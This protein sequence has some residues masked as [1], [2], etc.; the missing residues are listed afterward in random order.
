MIRRPP[1]ST[2]FPYTT[3]FRSHKL[4][5]GIWVRFQFYGECKE[6][7]KVSSHLLFV[8]FQLMICSSSEMTQPT[9]LSIRSLTVAKRVQRRKVTVELCQD[10]LIGSRIL[11]R[12]R[13][14]EYL[15]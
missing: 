9:T 2:L 8:T 12:Y 3:L 14:N 11:Q 1:R 13:T 6:A 15:V 10:W 7:V 4:G 5:N